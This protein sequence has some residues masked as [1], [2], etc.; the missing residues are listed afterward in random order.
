[1]GETALI[2]ASEAGFLNVVDFLISKK[3]N[4]N[5][6]DKAGNSALV[7]SISNGFDDVSLLLIKHGA[8]VSAA[9]TQSGSAL[10]IAA[11]SGRAQIVVAIAGEHPELLNKV[12]VD[13]E[14]P[15]FAAI[16][17][18]HFALA[19]KMIELGSHIDAKNSKG[20]TALDVAKASGVPEGHTLLK[21]LTPAETVSK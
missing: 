11:K 4:V 13:G 16:R 17:E 14:P 3:A 8:D 15:L 21:K 1:M 10:Q 20:Q 5:L 7:Y 12:G 19:E 2:L 6:R 18:A 9:S